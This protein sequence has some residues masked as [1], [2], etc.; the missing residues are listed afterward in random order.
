MSEAKFSK[1]PRKKDLRPRSCGRRHSILLDEGRYR[2]IS[3]AP[4]TPAAARHE[5]GATHDARR[6]RTGPPLRTS[7]P[8]SCLRS[9]A[10]RSARPATCAP[11]PGRS[12][13]RVGFTLRVLQE[14]F[15]ARHL[16]CKHDGNL[17]YPASVHALLTEMDA[18]QH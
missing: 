6:A 17:Q 18:E 16:Q 12:T 9:N 2:D 1:L 7:L 11:A 3:S 8:Q 5:P 10:S 13:F 15:L 14:Y 4:T